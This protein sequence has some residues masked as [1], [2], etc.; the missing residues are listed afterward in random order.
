MAVRETGGIPTIRIETSKEQ[1]MKQKGNCLIVLTPEEWGTARERC[2]VAGRCC[3]F[4]GASEWKTMLLVA[5]APYHI[6]NE[7]IELSHEIVQIRLAESMA[8]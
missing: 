7:C 6:C 5:R 3:N 8:A 2:R 4:C 1:P